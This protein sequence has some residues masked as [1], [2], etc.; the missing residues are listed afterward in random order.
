MNNNDIICAP[1]TVP[2]TG[3]ISVIRV[4]GKG[5]LELADKVISLRKGSIAQ[6]KGYTLHFGSIFASDGSLLDEVIVSV[7]R[8]PNSY[9][10]EDGV[11]ISCHSSKYIVSET[12]GLLC[13]KGC[14]MAGPGEFTQRAYLNGKM[15]LAQA[16]AVADVIAADSK[17]ALRVAQSQLRGEYSAAFKELR[18]ALVR[19]SALV[20]LELDFS[21]EEVEFAS[22]EM[23][24]GL[25]ESAIA[26]MSRLRDS[27]RMGNALK[28]GV[29]VAIVG[30][31]NVGKSTLLN[32]LLGE[33]RAITSDIPGTTR[34]TVEESI[35]IEGVRYRFIDTAGIRETEQMI[36]RLGIERSLA[37]IR[38]AAIVIC[39][40]DA[41]KK[42]ESEQ[43]LSKV[44]SLI[45]SEN[46][47]IIVVANKSDLNG[48]VKEE[49]SGLSEGAISI[50]AL[51]KEGLR[52]LEKA[53]VKCGF[54]D[55]DEHVIVTSA[56]HY[57]ALS[58][59]VESL[60]AVVRAVREGISE[61][62][63]AED[64][65]AA[66][67]DINSIFASTSDSIT[68]DEVLGE[69]FGKFCIGK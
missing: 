47:K 24:I 11:E 12:I 16:E 40:L 35:V 41:T 54:A 59:A 15:D 39:L 21:E 49:L 46:Q 22:R 18:D 14:R 13:E 7:F 61:E 37:K 64:L 51:R 48:H 65:R 60:R 30:A 57:N 55:T 8:A 56:R 68:P 36:E 52:E 38:D 69:V 34:D 4:S 19:L 5:S 20:E 2:G 66:I 17:A 67:C 6:S 27:Y 31:P 63:L 26:K 9:T 50:S 3:A 29:P 42:D 32:A 45:D 10:G 25:A 43:M 62:L 1:A 33:D 23:I 53:I 44:E 28:N 58:S